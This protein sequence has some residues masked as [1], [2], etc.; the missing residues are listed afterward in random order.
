M[1]SPPPSE[2]ARRLPGVDIFRGLAVLLM[3]PGNYLVTVAWIPAWLKHT[4]DVGLTIMDLGAPFFILA[5]GLTYR[6][7]LLRR[8][9][10]TGLGSAYGHI[11]TRYLALIGLGAIFSTAQGLVGKGE[12]NW[13][14]LQAIGAAGLIT[15]PLARHK[16]WVRL[17]GGGL[18]LAVY[19]LLLDAGGWAPVVLGQVHGGLPG[20]LG[21]GAMLLLSTVLAELYLDPSRRRW[22]ALAAVGLVLAG[23]G[24]SEMGVAISK[25]RVSASYVLVSLAAGAALLL[26]VE[27]FSG[28]GSGWLA[29]LLAAWGRNPLLLYVLHLLLLALVELP[30]DPAWY[31]QVAPW[32]A[33]VQI[34]A[35][36]AIL[37]A[38]ALW[39]ERRKLIFSL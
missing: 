35:M 15:L 39:L 29:R 32:L 27:V 8:A 30:E 11:L 24:L 1:Q 25:N 26:L 16:A 9:E 28:K 10:R 21:W 4:P 13:G 2:P 18:L 33:A 17:L 23:A 22:L 31:T 12:A 19:Q 5:I 34:T 7:A 6:L 3:V 14:V 38:A 20:S 37:S 36:L